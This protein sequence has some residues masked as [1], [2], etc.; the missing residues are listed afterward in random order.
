MST[1]AYTIYRLL[2]HG[3]YGKVYQ[4]SATEPDGSRRVVAL[5]LV[6]PARVSEDS[7][8]GL[9]DEA[10][11]AHLLDDP[12]VVQVEP[13]ILLEGRWAVEMEFVDGASLYRLLKEHPR[14]P[15]RPAAELV[16]EV[17]RALDKLVH[18]PGPH[19][20]PL[21]FVHRDLKPGNIQL[22][23]MGEVKLLDFGAAYVHGLSRERPAT[24]SDVV[25]G[26]RGYIAPERF[27]NLDH[28]AGDV[29]ALG[30]L[31]HHMITGA[32]PGTL[33]D[34]GPLPPG[35]E[36]VLRI[37]EA[38]RHREWTERI[39]AAQA[40]Q[41]LQ[42]IHQRLP[43]PTLAEWA[44]VV[45]PIPRG[46]PPDDLVGRTLH[47][48]THE[49]PLYSERRKG[50][51]VTPVALLQSDPVMSEPGSVV[52]A[53]ERAHARPPPSGLSWVLVAALTLAAALLALACGGGIGAIAGL[54]VW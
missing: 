36:E 18:Q 54:L 51:T 28:P 12:A 11:I 30:V 2:G 3:G 43:G 14:V 46:L 35:G 21:G 53:P 47:V 10:R 17:L 49:M 19:G 34:T 20:G 6:D 37:T 5:K 23:P 32:L 7:L 44:R 41:R 39:D 25:V 24:D 50:K 29:Y 22:T 42:A 40:R 16:S 13:P 31:L 26:T 15:P 33:S 8:A 1:R 45:R 38:M 48:T 27:E 9:R 52:P 4:A